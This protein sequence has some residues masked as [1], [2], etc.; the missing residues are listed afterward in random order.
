MKKF[1]IVMLILVLAG[2]TLQAKA[3][4]KGKVALGL[5]GL[6]AGLACVVKG[7]PQN[8]GLRPE[9]VKPSDN[10]YLLLAQKYGVLCVGG[11]L[12]GFGLTYI[13]EGL[14]H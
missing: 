3:T 11:G 1:Q 13:Q 6:V 5:A 7:E 4:N 14:F 8:Y 9:Q 12:T 2:L 10:T